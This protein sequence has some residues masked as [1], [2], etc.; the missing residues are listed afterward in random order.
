VD[1]R[2][3]L[4][5]LF[6]LGVSI[7]VCIE[8]ILCNIGTFHSPGPGFFPFWSAVIMGMFSVLLLVTISLRKK[9]KRKI[10]DLWKGVE[11]QKIIWVLISLFLYPFVL[12][13]MGYLITTF[14]LMAFS[15]GI[16]GKS[17]VWVLGVSALII[18]LV[19]YIIFDIFLTIALP[20][21]IL[22]F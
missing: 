4:S 11:W 15:V 1:H 8:S 5:G 9:W 20:K 21:G 16:M 14:G 12:P 19:S 2:D 17:K 7:F 13:I 3:L 10:A 18:T 22:G 6:W